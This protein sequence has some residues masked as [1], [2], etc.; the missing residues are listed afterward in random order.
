MIP[1]IATSARIPAWKSETALKRAV[2][3]VSFLHIHGLLS[4]AERSQV[5][6]RICRWIERVSRSRM[7]TESTV[8]SRHRQ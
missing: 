1:G 7:P 5:K 6:R 8:R 2:S 3:C 4:D